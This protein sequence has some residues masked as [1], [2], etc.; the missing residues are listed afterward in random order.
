MPPRSTISRVADVSDDI[1]MS[2]STDNTRVSRVSDNPRAI[3]SPSVSIKTVRA[4][5]LE[6][7]PEHGEW[8]IISKEWYSNDFIGV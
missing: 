8:G 7:P 5:K 4:M 1:A 3:S 6:A 2:I